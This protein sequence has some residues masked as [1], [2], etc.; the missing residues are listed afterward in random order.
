M[1]RRGI[2]LVSAALALGLVGAVA[3]FAQRPADVVVP[4]YAIAKVSAVSATPRPVE[5]VMARG[6][7]RVLQRR[8]TRVGACPGSLGCPGTT[9]LRPTP[10]FLVRAPDGLIRAF[11]GEDPRNGC[12]LE[13]QPEY[14]PTADPGV[15]YDVCHGS[16]YDRRGQIA[17][18]PAF[19]HLNQLAVE[20]R[21]DDVYVHPSRIIVGQ[22]RDA[23][24][25]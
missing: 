19:W 9:M 20:I 11:I 4:P 14:G 5:V 3:F 10:I 21:G 17:G 16:Q 7:D 12:A 22:C 8:Q 15:F 2:L 23:P 18:G 1:R 6:S 24:N 13:W 25:C